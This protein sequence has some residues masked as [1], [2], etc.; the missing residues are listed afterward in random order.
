[1]PRK[2]NRK[3]KRGT[4]VYQ[5]TS[6]YIWYF[7]IVLFMIGLIVLGS[8][9][10]FLYER[11]QQEQELLEARLTEL[12]ATE[13]TVN[14]Q[15]RLDAVLYPEYAEYAVEI[16]LDDEVLARSRG[17]EDIEEDGER[18]NF[19]GLNQF[20]LQERD[21]LFYTDTF[22]LEVNGA[23]ALVET[24]SEAD[25]EM[26]FFVLLFQ[27]L[28]YT[29]IISLLIGSFVIYRL[30]ARSLKPLST[31]TA[32]VAALG[33]TD[34]LEK[35]I[36]VPAKP[37]E[38][39]E[40]ATVFNRLLHQLQQQFERE[41]RFV[42][43]ASHE[44]RTPLTAFRGHLKLLKRWG[45]D[46]P[47][48]LVQGLE[49]MDQE[50]TRMERMVVQLLTLARTGHTETKKEPLNLSALVKTVIAQWPASEDV[51]VAAEV[52]EGITVTGDA[53]QLRQVAVI[54]L[55][56]AQRYT[57]A[58]SI[59]VRLI[60]DGTS[61]RLEVKDTGIGIAPADQEKV[62]DRFYRV[63]K[64]RSRVSGGTGLGLSIASELVDH[65]QGDIRLESELGKGST[66]TVVLPK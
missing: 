39:T 20:V 1:M 45:K 51:S 21:D 50:S 15:E 57:E 61:V 5:V 62:F 55:E 8:V 44:L 64:A 36:P 33:G 16:R 12:T 6:W 31:I 30:T 13:E 52:G 59:T 66:F 18:L 49:A 38:L 46:D 23:L 10:F 63:D 4:L 22:Q 58:G 3:Q 17:W 65:H 43:D 7:V 40:L 19:F 42:S 25:D 34:D 35:R 56:N 24:G 11:I 32:A 28:L 29:G 47:E 48:I 53:E 41:Q 60:E 26:E 9:G 37:G 14:L 54:L 27:I 2:Q